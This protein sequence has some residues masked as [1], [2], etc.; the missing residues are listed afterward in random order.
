VT[1]PQWYGSLR[2][3]I[4]TAQNAI[5]DTAGATA[6]SNSPSVSRLDSVANE[7]IGHLSIL[8]DTIRLLP[9]E[10]E[11]SQNIFNYS[12]N[13]TWRDFVESI[14][15]QGV[16]DVIRSVSSQSVPPFLLS[17]PMF[18]LQDTFQESILDHLSAYLSDNGHNAFVGRVRPFDFRLRMWQLLLDCTRSIS[19]FMLVDSFQGGR[20]LSVLSERTCHSCLL[21]NTWICNLMHH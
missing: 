5:D 11:I 17:S 10:R 18:T 6:R 4:S 15:S 1:W 14:P 12:T 16:L 19:C 7:E 20:Y 8:A 3:R 2:A 9:T 13:L 21:G